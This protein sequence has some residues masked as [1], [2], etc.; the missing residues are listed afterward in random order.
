MTKKQEEHLA[1]IK[2]EFIENVDSKYRIGQIDH[3]GNLWR[4]KGM[5]DMAIEEVIDLY[6][7]LITLK[8]QQK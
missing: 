4:K 8:E 2:K 3:G 7:Y 6:V 5:L 1:R